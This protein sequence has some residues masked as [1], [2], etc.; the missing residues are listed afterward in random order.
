MTRA[1]RIRDV[2]FEPVDPQMGSHLLR[3]ASEL[4]ALEKRFG[5]QLESFDGQPGDIM[6]RAETDGSDSVV[7]HLDDV[8]PGVSR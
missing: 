3:F 5:V 4:A 6:L 7:V 8:R 2:A 1:Q